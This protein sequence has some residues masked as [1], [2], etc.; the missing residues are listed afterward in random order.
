MVGSSSGVKGSKK[1]TKKKTEMNL[2][3]TILG[4]FLNF[5]N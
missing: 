4:L 5:G 3:V 2:G 1:K